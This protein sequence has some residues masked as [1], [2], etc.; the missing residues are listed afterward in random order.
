MPQFTRHP[1]EVPIGALII[2][3][4]TTCINPSCRKT[5]IWKEPYLLENPE[6]KL[7]KG[8]MVT[9]S[10]KGSGEGNNWLLKVYNAEEEKAYIFSFD[11][12]RDRVKYYCA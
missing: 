5:I 10:F 4:I 6:I 9:R 8:G 3:I 12:D 2:C 1:N 11:M 7:L